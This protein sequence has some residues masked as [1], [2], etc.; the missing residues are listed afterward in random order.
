MYL[1]QRRVGAGREGF[2]SFSTLGAAKQYILA[3][4]HPFDYLIF[5]EEDLS[6][7][8]FDTDGTWV[9][10]EDAEV[11]IRTRG[12]TRYDERVRESDVR[13]EMF[14]RAAQSGPRG[15]MRRY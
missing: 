8:V 6:S 5:D 11:P 13:Q 10:E 14:S 12:A 15:M 7:I 2:R 9:S 4:G 1:V 3:T